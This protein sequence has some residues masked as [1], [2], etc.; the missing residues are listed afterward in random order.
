MD[1]HHT[2]ANCS[3]T[4]GIAFRG[5]AKIWGQDQGTRGDAELGES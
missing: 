4:C 3:W 5:L 2:S 1:V